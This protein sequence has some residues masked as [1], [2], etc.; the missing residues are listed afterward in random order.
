MNDLLEGMI[1]YE[2]FGYLLERRLYKNLLQENIAEDKI[3]EFS[4]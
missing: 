4:L 3:T 2:L 1:C